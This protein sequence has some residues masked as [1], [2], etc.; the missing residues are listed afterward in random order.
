MSARL[1]VAKQRFLLIKIFSGWW[2]ISESLTAHHLVF[3]SA[4]CSQDKYYLINTLARKNKCTARM[5]ANA[6]KGHSIP[7]L[8]ML[9]LIFGVS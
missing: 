5:L 6:N 7:L 2:K 1:L 3:S 9:Q 8:C 4:R